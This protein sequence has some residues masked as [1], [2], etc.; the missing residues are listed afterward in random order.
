MRAEIDIRRGGPSSIALDGHDVA[1]GVH[2]LTLTF[3]VSDVPRLSLDLHLAEDVA[4]S[5]EVQVV[6][7]DATAELLTRLGWTPPAA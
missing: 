4:F 3:A 1:D 7:P 5:G 2:G 6:I